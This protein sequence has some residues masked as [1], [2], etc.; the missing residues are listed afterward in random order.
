[1]KLWAGITRCVCG[2]GPFV[3]API[4][5]V[6]VGVRGL[7]AY[8]DTGRAQPA[9]SPID[10]RGLQ[11]CWCGVVWEGGWEG[12]FG[13]LCRASSGNALLALCLLLLPASP[14]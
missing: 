1:M 5:G 6:V 3:S 12:A 11:L 2:G 10:Q 7:A 13:P 9:Q 14:S 8:C 4:R